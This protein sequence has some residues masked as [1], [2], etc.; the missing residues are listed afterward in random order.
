MTSHFKTPFIKVGRAVLQGD[1]LSPL[2]FNMCFNTFIQYIKSQN[3]KHLGFKF[4]TNFEPRHWFQFANDAS[5][6]SDTEHKNQILLNA[7]TR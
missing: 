6:I 4:K 5:V 2:T 1:C 3:F 7:F